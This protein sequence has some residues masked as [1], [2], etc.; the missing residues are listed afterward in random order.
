MK[1]L[2]IDARGCAC[3]EPVVLTNQALETPGV[4]R[5]IVCVDNENAR[6]NVS[7]MVK[8]KGCAVTV[9]EKES[10]IYELRITKEQ[11]SVSAPGERAPAAPPVQDAVVYLFDADYIGSNRDLGKVLVN[12]FLKAALAHAESRGAVVLLSNGVRLA[13]EGS[14]ALEVMRQ[15]EAGGFRILICGTCLDFFKIRQKVKIGTISNALEILECMTAA[16]KVVKF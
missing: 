16:G 2:D 12:G 1:N 11:I 10:G 9:A 3:P 14:Y 13:T 15:M 4:H 5:V 6:D 7:R 8:R